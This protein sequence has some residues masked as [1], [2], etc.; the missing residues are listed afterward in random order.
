MKKEREPG[1]L[2]TAWIKALQR[3]G[4]AINSISTY[5][6]SLQKFR[7]MLQER[8][9]PLHRVRRVDISDFAMERFRRG[10][11]LETTIHFVDC[12]RQFF[13]LHYQTLGVNPE[14]FAIGRVRKAHARF[15][16][17]GLTPT[18]DNPR[19]D[20]SHDLSPARIRELKGAHKVSHPR[21]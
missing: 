3:D 20:I 6:Q 9:I 11:S 1:P 14:W 21:G 16:K 15:I 10:N 13:K 18:A 4:L 8:S 7:S 12:I 19:S 17:A 5:E 2:T